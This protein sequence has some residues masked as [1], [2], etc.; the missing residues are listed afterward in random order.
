MQVILTP[1]LFSS[2]QIIF[3]NSK[4]SE[5]GT[6]A[7]DKQKNQYFRLQIRK[8]GWSKMLNDETIQT[9]K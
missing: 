3:K 4:L 8:A 7:R 9:Y 1:V 2:E 5:F 6:Y